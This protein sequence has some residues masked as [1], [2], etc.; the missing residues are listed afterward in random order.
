MVQTGLNRHYFH[1][2]SSEH[3]TVNS[4]KPFR[5]LSASSPVDMWSVLDLPGDE[6]KGSMIN[7][8]LCPPLWWVA[9]STWTFTG[10]WIPP[11]KHLSSLS[12]LCASLSS[13][14]CPLSLRW[15]WTAENDAVKSSQSSSLEK[16]LFT[17]TGGGEPQ[18]S[19]VQRKTSVEDQSELPDLLS[20]G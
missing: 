20:L 10:S 5:V 13:I 12:K 2:D 3:L 7:D 4:Y 17:R 16:Q 18:E 8:R 6:W 19:A 15:R 9:F 14:E 1:F 11:S